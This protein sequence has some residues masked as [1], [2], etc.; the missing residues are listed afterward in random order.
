MIFKLSGTGVGQ[1]QAGKNQGTFYSQHLVV[2]YGLITPTWLH[3]EQFEYQAI[4]GQAAS[5]QGED[6]LNMQG[7]DW[8][9]PSYGVSHFGLSRL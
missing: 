9:V 6:C 7:E 2:H 4:Q 5:M 3:K 1:Q 8:R